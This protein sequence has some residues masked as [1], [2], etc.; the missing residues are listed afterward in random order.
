MESGRNREE[1]VDLVV[2][3]EPL[4][5]LPQVAVF[6][7]QDTAVSRRTLGRLVDQGMVERV[8][9][10]LYRRADAPVVDLDLAELGLRSPVATVCLVSALAW[11]DLV[12]EVPERWHLAVPRGRHTVTSEVPVAWHVFDAASFEVGREV[13]R[14]D[15]SESVIGV[16]GPTRSVVDAFRLRRLVGHELAVEALKTWLGRRGN[17]PAELVEL[18]ERLPRASGPLRRTLE[19]LL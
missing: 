10:G 18:A 4:R 12:T 8:G 9:H 16:Y 6:R 17:H 3:G 5:T 14:I 13:H 15:G 2:R 19:V 11:H 1:R 7:A